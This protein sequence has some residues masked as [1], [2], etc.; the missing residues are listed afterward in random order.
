MRIPLQ[1][2]NTKIAVIAV[3]GV[4]AAVYVTLAGVQFLASLLGSRAQLSSLRTAAWLEPGN[5]EYRFREGR[6]Q[7]LV[8]RDANAAAASYRAAV[9]LNPHQARYWF[10]L[11]ATYEL[12]GDTSAEAN[13]LD[14]AIEADPTTPEVA[15][16]AANFF[17]VQGQMDK[18]MREFRVVLANDPTLP[19]V[20]LPLLWRIE[21]DIDLLLRDVIP[22][23]AS[24]YSAFLEYL[25]SHKQ[26]DAANKVWARLAPLHQPVERRYVFTYIR[27]LLLDQQ[28]DQARMVWQQSAD[29]CDLASYEPTPQNLIV[30]G[31]FSLDVL[32]GGFDWMY[33]HSQQVSLLLDPTQSES[34]H[35][36]LLMTF[37]AQGINDAGIR[38][39]VPVLPN[40][41]Y[42]FS[43]YYKAQDIEA[44]GGLR[45]A[46]QDV[47]NAAT[48]FSSDNLD[49]VEFWKPIVGDFVTGPQTK[50]LVVHVQRFPPGPIK[51]KVWIDTIKLTQKAPATAPAQGS[52]S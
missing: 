1:S 24:V 2:R 49:N 35:R 45:F 20:A 26:L 19:A 7:R 31:D 9:A 6:Y 4:L 21:P 23:M 16:Q 50:L 5:A 3:V 10:D 12:L 44:A 32:N 40:T 42:E 51:G 13:A 46:I 47:Y 25:V 39:V 36:S 29:L 27:S 30:N 22:P 37:D 33:D 17:V 34:G 38:Q 11:A 8:E 28:V 14:R 52:H 41:G 48:F 43:A 15:W 18:A